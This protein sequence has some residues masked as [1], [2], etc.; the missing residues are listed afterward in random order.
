MNKTAPENEADTFI[1][2][3][4]DY[5]LDIL[6]AYTKSQKTMRE[7]TEFRFKEFGNGMS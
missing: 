4:A 7:N 1:R 3:R 6:L 2:N 5:A